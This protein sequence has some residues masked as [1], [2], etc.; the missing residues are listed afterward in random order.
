MAKT[1]LVCGFCG[2]QFPDRQKLKQ[3]TKAK[4]KGAT[5]FEEAPDEEL[6]YPPPEA[7]YKE[8]EAFRK[9]VIAVR[10][11]RSKTDD[12][13]KAEKS[14]AAWEK[15]MATADIFDSETRRGRLLF[16]ASGQPP[17]LKTFRMGNRLC[18]IRGTLSLD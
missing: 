14:Q 13:L 9:A 17:K 15:R 18:Y 16:R 7:S 2:N 11:A 10:A 1:V 12:V 4:H 5:A 3:H 8:L 6:E